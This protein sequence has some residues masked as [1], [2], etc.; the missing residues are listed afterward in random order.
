MVGVFVDKC[1]KNSF[2]FILFIVIS[3]EN[4]DV[5]NLV[6][7]NLDASSIS[8]FSLLGFDFLQHFFRKIVR[9][10]AVTNVEF[11]SDSGD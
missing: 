10:I 9:K 1:F 3:D 5:S 7:L 2:V 4:V 6:C 11:I 8:F